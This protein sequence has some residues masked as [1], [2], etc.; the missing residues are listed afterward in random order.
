MPSSKIAAWLSRLR[1]ALAFLSKTEPSYLHVYNLFLS[2]PSTQVGS[3]LLPPPPP[4]KHGDLQAEIDRLNAQLLA[5]KTAH[6][7]QVEELNAQLLV[8][9]TS[10]KEGVKE[11]ER[12]HEREVER[13][14]QERARRLEEASVVVSVN[15][16][17][18]EDL[19]KEIERLRKVNHAGI[20]AGVAL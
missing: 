14:H 12:A 10:H 6:E 3:S 1:Y 18:S 9:K 11:L 19:T 15:C 7:K 8:Q 16:Q 2:R 17:V 5:E 13:V 4:C 20:Q